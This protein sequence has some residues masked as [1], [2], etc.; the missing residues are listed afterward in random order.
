LEASVSSRRLLR[1]G[2]SFLAMLALALPTFAAPG[3]KA[4]VAKSVITPEKAVWLA[5]YGSKRVP[6]GKL[7]DLWMKALALE[8]AEGRR[9]V[10]ITSDFQGVPKM[11]SDRVFEQL[12][13]KFQ[14]TRAQV[15]FTFSH[16]HCG[17]RLGDDL[18]DYYPVEAEQVALVEEYTA[19]MVTNCVAMVGESLAKLAPAKLQQGEGKATFAVNRRNN[20]EAEVPGIIARGEPLK[21]PVDHSVPVLTVTR[22]DGKLAAVLFG[23]A[24]HPTTLSFMTWCGDY[25]GF[26]QMEIEKAHPGATAM[27]VNT[28]GGD[29]NPLPRRSVELCE[30]YGKLLAAGV[31]EALKQP[32]KPVSPGLRTAFEIIDLPYLKTVSREELEAVAKESGGIRGRWA[33][34]MLQEL[35][36]RKQFPAAYP[37]PVHAWRLGT[38]MLVIGMG[39]ETVVDYA[40]RFKREFGPGTWVMG[41]ADDMIAYIPSRRVW[42]EGG[43]EGGTF[44]FEYGRP[45]FRW[46]GDIEDR[47]SASVHQLVKQV[48]IVKAGQ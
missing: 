42:E 37:Y 41:Y 30:R 15:M 34:R 11:M 12:A 43:Y 14:L 39:A 38:E 45:A 24:C 25:P 3:W 44:L 46:A 47:I 17:P 16:N 28:C 2:M 21:G 33:T 40:L 7:H 22:P 26:A 4:G 5:G 6:T 10:L 48:G 35:D 20:Q 36:R 9:V 8:D 1:L 31:A 29:Q 27:F 23:Y 18:V 13:R 32:L 19:L